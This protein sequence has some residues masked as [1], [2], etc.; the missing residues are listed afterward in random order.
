MTESEIQCTLYDA[1][2][3]I[4]EY[5]DAIEELR[6]AL[7]RKTKANDALRNILSGLGQLLEDK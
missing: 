5:K 2:N 1:E 7:A 6:E 4:R 3:E